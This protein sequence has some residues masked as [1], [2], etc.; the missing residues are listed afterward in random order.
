MVLKWMEEESDVTI[1]L[2]GSVGENVG[3]LSWLLK[4]KFWQ[5]SND[6]LVLT[7][8]NGKYFVAYCIDLGI[9]LGVGVRICAGEISIF[10]CDW[11]S[12]NL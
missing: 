10:Q 1:D 2:V 7:N 12:E 8:C 4:Q 11:V 5:G 6:I 9:Q 3:N